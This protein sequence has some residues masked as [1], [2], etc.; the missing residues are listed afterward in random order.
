MSDG[1]KEAESILCSFELPGIHNIHVGPTNLH[2]KIEIKGSEVEVSVPITNPGE[3]LQV[4]I[5]SKEL[6]LQKTLPI[7]VE[8]RSITGSNKPMKTLSNTEEYFT[9]AFIILGLLVAIVMHYAGVITNTNNAILPRSITASEKNLM[10]P[11]KDKIES[12]E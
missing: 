8:A 3:D 2:G 12:L 10:K 4:L 6:F 9:I 1:S 11:L 5:Y 7:Q